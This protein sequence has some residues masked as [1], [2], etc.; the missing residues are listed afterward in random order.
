MKSSRAALAFT[1][2][3]AMIALIVLAGV[4]SASLQLRAQALRGR[5]AAAEATAR[6]AALQDLLNQAVAGFLGEPAQ[7]PEDRDAPILRTVWIG[8]LHGE[9]YEVVRE[10]AQR[11]NP[12]PRNGARDDDAESQFIWI[13]HWSATWRGQTI[14]ERR[15]P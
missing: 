2:L 5:A 11:P 4:A 12:V 6:E 8:Q 9:P 14:E 1:L 10:V 7:R 3:E 13:A 15:I